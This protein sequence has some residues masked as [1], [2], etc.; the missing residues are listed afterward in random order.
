MHL[1]GASEPVHL[2]VASE[3][4][5]HN[6]LRYCPLN[7]YLRDWAYLCPG[8]LSPV[9][10]QSKELAHGG[11]HLGCHQWMY[12][13]GRNVHRCSGWVDQMAPSI[14][15][16][17]HDSGRSV[18]ES[19]G[20]GKICDHSEWPGASSLVSEIWQTN[21]QVHPLPPRKHAFYNF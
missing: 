14:N 13:C 10:V 15:P 17:L 19:K 16:T 4:G 1:S 6:V 21:L 12:L 5:A 8:S 7:G 2:S 11:S 3:H 9:S 20:R 18:D